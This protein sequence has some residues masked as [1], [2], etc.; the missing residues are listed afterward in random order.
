MSKSQST[1]DAAVQSAI[2]NKTKPL[3]ALGEI[4]A[5]A[6]KIAHIQQTLTPRAETCRLVIFAGD[7][8]MARAGVSAYPQEVT[9]QMVLNFLNGGA[10]ANVFAQSLGVDIR[11]V[12]AGVAG[13]PIDHPA[14]VSKRIAAGTRNAIEE[15]A[16]TS[17]QCDRALS[18]GESIGRSEPHDVN[19]FGEM[20]IGNTSSASLMASKV[21]GIDVSEIVGRGTGLDDE[22][23]QRKTALLESAANRTNGALSG[24]DALAEYGGFEIAMITGAMIGAAA[25]GKV[26]LIDGFIATAAALCARDIAPECA[27]S[28][29][30]AHRSAESGHG[31][32]LDY[33]DA[34][35]LL[36]LDM[37]L[38]EGTGAL[39]AWPLVKSAAAMMRDMASFDSASVSGPA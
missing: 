21:M 3:G 39:L 16:M 18:E 38:G 31:K 27:Q 37:R 1:F 13:A 29:I 35:P 4:E 7:H 12:D 6:A 8:G 11:V 2:D 28:F 14:L 32:I 24:R 19:C 22:G 17:A 33:L 15:P 5:V 26:V 9:Q 34:K 25:K 30:Y 20:G 10:A 36:D 23:L